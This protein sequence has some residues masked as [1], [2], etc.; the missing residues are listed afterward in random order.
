VRFSTLPGR[1]INPL[2]L[3]E[4]I[5]GGIVMGMSNALTEE[6]P[7][8]KGVPRAQWLARYKRPSIKHTPGR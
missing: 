7:H 8:E 6:F 3:E 2:A 1:A 5:E 4:Q